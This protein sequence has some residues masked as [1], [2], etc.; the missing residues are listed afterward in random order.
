M[1]PPTV[2]YMYMFVNPYVDYVC[3]PDA[4]ITIR[5]QHGAAHRLVSKHFFKKVAS[6]T[7]EHSLGRKERKGKP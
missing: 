5:T 1:V 7:N 4:R 6:R 3:F 2:S